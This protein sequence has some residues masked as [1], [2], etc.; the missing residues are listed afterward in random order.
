MSPEREREFEELARYL[1]YFATHVSGIEPGSHIHPTTV[2][3]G[4]V[5]SHG[6][7]KALEGL[8]QA[9]NDTVEELAHDHEAAKALDQALRANGLLGFYEVARRYAGAYRKTIKRGR[10]QDETEYHL[11]QGALI[12]NAKG[13]TDNERSLLAKLV[14]DFENTASTKAP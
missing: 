6:R 10:I 4:T 13:L 3:A 7:S 2:L 11:M 1:D 9:A 8:R 5:A 14:E 12:D